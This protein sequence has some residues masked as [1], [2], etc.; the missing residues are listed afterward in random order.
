MSSTSKKR[1]EAIDFQFGL[2]SGIKKPPGSGFKFSAAEC[3]T[4]SQ[5]TKNKAQGKCNTY[6][7]KRP[8]LYAGF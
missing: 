8:V 1:L 6:G 5:T 2:S 7:F 4:R 3:L